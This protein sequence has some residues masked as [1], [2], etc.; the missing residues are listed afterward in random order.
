MACDLLSVDSGSR[1][2]IDLETSL[3]PCGSTGPRLLAEDSTVS[4]H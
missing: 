4:T 1:S 2:E 3:A